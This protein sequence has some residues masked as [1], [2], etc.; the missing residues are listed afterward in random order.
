M[1]QKKVEVSSAVKEEY[2]CVSTFLPLKSWFNVIPFLRM[3]AA[4]EKQLK[5][6]RGAVRYGLKTDI[7]RKRFWTIS[8][9]SDKESMREF[10]TNEPHLTAIRNFESWAGDGAAFVEYA[11]RTGEINWSE[12]ESKLQKPS[13]Y[14]RRKDTS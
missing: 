10:V 6:T 3:T 8:V 13:F 2:F 5:D 1:V 11:S 7:F 9:W 4:I 12:A 14:Y